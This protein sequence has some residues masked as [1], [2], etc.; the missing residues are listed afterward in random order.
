M[1]LGFLWQEHKSNSDNDTK[2]EGDFRI[3]KK[4]LA[5]LYFVS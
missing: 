5:K 1:L 3:K 4:F 2:A